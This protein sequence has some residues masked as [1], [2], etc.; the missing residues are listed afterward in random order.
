M[1]YGPNKY[2][3]RRE[4]QHCPR[5]CTPSHYLFPAFSQHCRGRVGKRELHVV[6]AGVARYGRQHL[7][8]ESLQMTEGP[9]GFVL[10]E[11]AHM[12]RGW[13]VYF[14]VIRLCHEDETTGSQKRGDGCQDFLHADHVLEDF[15]HKDAVIG[16]RRRE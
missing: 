3:S 2:Q 12:L 10:I 6:P 5:K 4:Q 16:S 14:L 1:R 7:V 8:V 11:L 15:E 13:L 9:P